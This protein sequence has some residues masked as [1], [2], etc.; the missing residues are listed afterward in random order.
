MVDGWPGRIQSWLFPPLCLLCGAPGLDDRDL[1]RGCQDELP[2]NGCACPRCAVPLTRAVP[3]GRCQRHPPSYAAT[4]APYLYRPPLDH[5]VTAM[6]FH[7]KLNAARLLGQLLGETL[8]HRDAALPDLIVPVPLHR[9]RLRER[10]FNQATELGRV[11][12]RRLGLPLAR[13]LVRRRRS[14]APQTRLDLVARRTNLR[15]A[16]T[17]RAPL[18]GE[19]LAL[20]DDV[21]TTGATAEELARTLLAAGAGSVELWAVARTPAPGGQG[22]AP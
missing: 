17:V 15:G 21:V 10:G 4:W 3:C 13:D 1:C 6:K 22:S 5:L 14:T 8:A 19:R 16:F 2:V 12:A 9:H 20:L 11:V 7:G 18:A